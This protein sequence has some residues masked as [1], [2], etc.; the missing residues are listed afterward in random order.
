MLDASPNESLS[1]SFTD[2]IYVSP[3]SQPTLRTP[4]HE[5]APD[6]DLSEESQKSRF[7]PWKYVKPKTCKPDVPPKF[8]PTAPMSDLRDRDLSVLDTLFRQYDMAD[9]EADVKRALAMLPP[10]PCWED[11]QLLIR[12][13]A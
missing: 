7:N 2:E 11:E 3:S 5:V 12:H 10:E 13:S 8:D 9:V 4:Q 6:L 1:D